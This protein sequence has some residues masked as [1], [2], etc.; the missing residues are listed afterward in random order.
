MSKKELVNQSI[1]YIL[2]HLNEDIAVDDVADYVH[3]S[4]YYFCRMFKEETGESIYSFIKHLKMDQSA[5]N[6]KLEKEKSITDIGLDYGYSSSNYSS[7]FKMRHHVSPTEFRK[8]T[9]KSNMHNPFYPENIANFKTFE[10]YDGCIKIKEIGDISV[11]YERVIG[12]YVELAEKW[13]QFMDTYKT[14]IKPDTRMIE[15]FYNDPSVT[16]LEQ[17]FC[18]LCITIDEKCELENLTTIKGGKF[19]VYC[20]KGQIA[21]IFCA[22]QGI[23]SIWLPQ[24]GFEMDRRY[25][26]NIYQKIDKNNHFVVMDLCIPIQ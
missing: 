23:F 22:L 10:E 15:R 25:G 9:D 13:F 12:N 24:S 19:A 1:D 14:Y 8:S 21:D 6:L 18:D 5:V 7:A 3:F 20:F 2:Q 17:C 26:L 4:K 11:I 16:N